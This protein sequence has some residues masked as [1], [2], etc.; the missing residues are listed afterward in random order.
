MMQQTNIW[1]WTLII[2]L[3]T[4]HWSK[5][6][7]G[8][9]SKRQMSNVTITPHP[10]YGLIRFTLELW[11]IGIKNG[12]VNAHISVFK[13]RLGY[14]KAKNWLYS[15]IL[16]IQRWFFISFTLEKAWKVDRCTLIS[17]GL[18]YVNTKVCRAKWIRDWF[19][20]TNF[21]V[22]VFVLF[23]SKKYMSFSS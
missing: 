17:V 6:C 8:N 21:I 23:C 15:V 19:G 5:E 22:L 7:T 11:F 1:I 20:P 14:N 3:P 4:H 16:N 13:T 9:A 18:N 2:N 10:W 12:N